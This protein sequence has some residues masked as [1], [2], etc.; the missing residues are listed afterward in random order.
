LDKDHDGNGRIVL[1]WKWRDEEGELDLSNPTDLEKAKRLINQG[2]G[3]EKGQ[4]ELKAVKGDLEK[5]KTDLEYWSSLIEEAKTTGDT[6]K[7]QH[8]LELLDVKFSKKQSNDDDYVL[9]EGDKKFEKLSEKVERLEGALY[10][11]YTTDMHSQLEAKYNGVNS[12]GGKYPEYNRKEIEDFANKRGIRDFED[13]YLIKYH[14]DLIKLRLDEDKNKDKK[15]A[16]KIKK[17]A[18]KE[19]GSGE[20]PPVPPSKHK[21]YKKASADWIKDSGITENLF[22]DD[23]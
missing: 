11:K 20:I 1:P 10:N 16:D 15:H 23:L 12:S 9:D 21:D 17:A 5:A 7:I 3:Y 22:T 6:S 18:S 4:Q 2:Y 19:P 14:D 13:A 8:A